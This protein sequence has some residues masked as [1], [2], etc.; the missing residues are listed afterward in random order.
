MTIV[1]HLPFAALALLAGC[2]DAAGTNPFGKSSDEAAVKDQLPALQPPIQPTKPQSID[3]FAGRWQAQDMPIEDKGFLVVDV[4]QDNGFVMEVRRLEGG[5][6]AIYEGMSGTL[7]L[8]VTGAVPSIKDKSPN[9][10]NIDKIGA[11]QLVTGPN[12]PQLATKSKIF[13]LKKTGV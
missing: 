10:R 3:Y 13:N 9:A 1:R 8:D 11:W 5:R 6:E 4:A 12:G 2:G 7:S